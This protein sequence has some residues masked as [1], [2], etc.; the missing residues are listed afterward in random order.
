MATGLDS[1]PG[2]T[3]RDV[4]DPDATA[5]GVGG[6]WWRSPTT[7]VAA[8]GGLLGGLLFLAAY[9]GMPDD[10]YITLDYAR[11]LVEH[12]HWGLTPFRHADSATSPLN[13]WLLAAGIGLTGRPVVAVGLLL[14]VTTAVTAV[15]AAG[16]AEAL[17]LRR[18]AVAGL[19]VGLLVT[20]PIFASVVGMEAFLAA[21]LLVGVARYGAADRVVPAGVV[22]GLAVL[23]RPDLAL[24]GAVVL[25]VLFLARDPRQPRPLVRAL[26][27]A[28]A[29]ALPWHVWSWFVLGT[30][31]P[32]SLVIKTGQGG[33]GE[34]TFGDGPVFLFDRWPGATV[35]V[36]AVAVAGLA[37]VGIAAVRWAR[38]AGRRS[39]PVV[40]ACGLAA[41]A[42]YAAYSALGVAPYTWYYCPSLGLLSVGAAIGAVELTGRTN[43]L[44]TS[45]VV[46]IGVATGLQAAPGVPWVAPVV[47]GNWTTADRYLA[48]GRELRAVLP[49]GASVQATG[50]IGL[51]A[52]ACECDIVDGFADQAH[53]LVQVEQARARGGPVT[54]WLL[55]F[56]YL[57]A[58]R[59]PPRPFQYTLR[60]EAGPGPG[61][62]TAGPGRGTGRFVLGPP[63][64]QIGA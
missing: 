46:V 7:A 4:P 49:P 3:S 42:H 25:A 58:D 44:A 33:P 50:E 41:A 13:V 48:V 40:V 64:P 61:W 1:A 47:F 8:G 59:T 5:R 23:A 34:A 15:W 54:R 62:P 20:S 18:A 28:V 11:N 12:G 27:L 30:F 55:G 36:G 43:V 63:G 31:V 6:R 22:T 29:V 52:F 24:P 39:D 38:G 51:L 35:L 45:L 21:A 19:T 14:V 26:G 60:W 9:R 32:D 53:V 57:H 10:S 37:A 2:A 56:N 16:L 17:R